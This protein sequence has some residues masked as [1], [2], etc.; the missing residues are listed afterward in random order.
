MANY[1]IGGK[2]NGS[3]CQNTC[4]EYIWKAVE[5]RFIGFAAKAMT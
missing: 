4:R 2:G 3:F 1:W 5:R